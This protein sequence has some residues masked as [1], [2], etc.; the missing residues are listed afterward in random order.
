MRN[1]DKTF[2]FGRVFFACKDWECLS[3][4][5]WLEGIVPVIYYSSLCSPQKSVAKKM[6]DFELCWR[7]LVP[8]AHGSYHWHTAIQSKKLSHLTPGLCE[9]I[10]CFVQ[11]L[12]FHL[13]RWIYFSDFFCS[14][15]HRQPN[16]EW[17]IWNKNALKHWW[18]KQSHRYFD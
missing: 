7:H 6:A 14:T 2:C 10:F 15:M 11:F 8:F 12:I 5:F 13:K 3:F 1:C 17:F 16:G 4:N 9:N 18:V